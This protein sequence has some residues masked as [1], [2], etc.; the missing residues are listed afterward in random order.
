[1]GKKKRVKKELE[2]QLQLGSIFE[3]VFD[4]QLIASILKET[5][6]DEELALLRLTDLKNAMYEGG[7]SCTTAGG[8]DDMGGDSSSQNNSVFESHIDQI[9]SIFQTYDRDVIAMMLLECENNMEKVIEIISGECDKAPL[10]LTSS[11]TT[12]TTSTKGQAGICTINDNTHIN[13]Q[14]ST[15]NPFQIIKYMLTDFMSTD[16]IEKYLQ[17]KQC[18][19]HSSLEYLQSVMNEILVFVSMNTTCDDI[20]D[21]YSDESLQTSLCDR[22][23]QTLNS[24]QPSSALPSSDFDMNLCLFES[25]LQFDREEQFDMPPLSFSD[26]RNELIVAKNIVWSF[27][28]NTAIAETKISHVSD[29]MIE[30]ALEL[31]KDSNFIGAYDPDSAISWICEEINSKKQNKISPKSRVVPN[32]GKQ[33]TGKQ[34]PSKSDRY[35]QC[36]VRSVADDKFLLIF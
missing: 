33:T 14:E 13:C 31:S 24:I 20:A 6:G 2:C 1:M 25:T 10:P 35:S 15:D 18:T 27:F 16:K 17:D 21:T 30:T 26:D 11:P 3:G 19:E 22:V 34:T 5:E 28:E 12:T 7:M 4:S 9:H 23:S 8:G 32:T 29:A 36:V